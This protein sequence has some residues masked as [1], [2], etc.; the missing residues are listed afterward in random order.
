M[1]N[2]LTQMAEYFK[3]LCDPT[4]LKIFRLLAA[5]PERNLCVGAIAH[6]VGVTQPAVSQHLKVLKSAG[7]VNPNRE[8]YRV[9]YAINTDTLVHFRSSVEEL[10]SLALDK[11]PCNNECQKQGE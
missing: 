1:E 7:L 9:H 10:C 8:G 2:M 11:H 6:R 3:A 4:R 5:N